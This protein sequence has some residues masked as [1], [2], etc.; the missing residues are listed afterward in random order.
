MDPNRSL[1][2]T[3]HEDMAE[4]EEPAVM[5]EAKAEDTPKEEIGGDGKTE[6]IKERKAAK[7][8][9]AEEESKEDDLAAIKEEDN[10]H[11]TGKAAEE[12]AANEEEETKGK[13]GTAK[14]RRKKQEFN[15][16][17]RESKRARK[18]VE[19][20]VTENF[21]ASKEK[22]SIAEG[23][24]SQLGSIPNVK[25]SIESYSNTSDDLAMAYKLLFSVRRKAGKADLKFRKDELFAFSGYLAPLVEG[26]DKEERAD[27]DEKE[28]VS[29]SI[30]DVHLDDAWSSKKHADDN[31]SQGL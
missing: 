24:G 23:R 20:F 19:T 10:G 15:L 21:T 6:G 2:T 8:L 5:T 7:E 12:E 17:A 18:S 9:K 14:K 16:P 22:V 11:D 26:E 4:V 30:C 13:D 25:A 3:S 1:G 29:F 28:E 31:V 27:L